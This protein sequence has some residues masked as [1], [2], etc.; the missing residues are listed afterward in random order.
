MTFHLSGFGISNTRMKLYFAKGLATQ[1]TS[2][3]VAVNSS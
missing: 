1:I 3:M 2:V